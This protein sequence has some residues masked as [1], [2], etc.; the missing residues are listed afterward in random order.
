M[1][2]ISFESAGKWMIS[3]FDTPLDMDFWVSGQCNM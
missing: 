2:K 3:D 1:N